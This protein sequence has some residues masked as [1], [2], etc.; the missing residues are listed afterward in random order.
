MCE[1]DE[2]TRESSNLKSYYKGTQKRDEHKLVLVII[3]CFYDNS[4]QGGQGLKKKF[5]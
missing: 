4:V 2:Q 5:N 1:R 3:P